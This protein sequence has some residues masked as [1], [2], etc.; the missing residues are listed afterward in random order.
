MMASYPAW[1]VLGA[2]ACLVV[3][4]ANVTQMMMK[5][6]FAARDAFGYFNLL[7]VLAPTLFLIALG[8]AALAVPMTASVAAAALA[9]A[10]FCGPLLML[11]IWLRLVRPSFHS[12][13]AVWRRISGYTY[14]SAGADVVVAL[15]AYL[16]RLILVPLVAE[17]AL[18]LYV[19]A[20]SF[21]RLLLALLPAINSVVFS[22]MT[23]RDAAAMKVL[24]DRAFRLALAALLVALAILMSVAEPLIGLV[25][26][27]A[28][29]AAG[30]LF[31]LL[32]VE[33]AL[34][35]LT[36]ISMRYLLALGLAG[37]ASTLQAGGL[38]LS[39]ALILALVPSLGVMGAA[40]GIT[41]ASAIK[42]FALL[43]VLERKGYGRTDLIL[44]RADIAYVRDKLR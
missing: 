41:V 40:L 43:V 22:S 27:A 21:S 28:F 11:P 42:L 1:A 38:I 32:A 8:V 17:G 23:D 3:A 24:H 25:Y 29:E 16:D 26:G 33:A 35:L 13:G 44:G 5:Q 14:R 34:T 19:V 2:Q 39:S 18:G 9:V 37:M 10:A 36:S 7:N 4:Y 30:P 6:T 31:R 15:A 12:I 20:F